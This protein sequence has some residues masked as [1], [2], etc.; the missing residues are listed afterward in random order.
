MSSSRKSITGYC[1]FIGDTLVSWKSK[2][3]AV[4]ARSS[5]EAEYRS[6]ASTCCELMWLKHLLADFKI[7][8][9]DPID[10][11]SDSQSAIHISKNPVFHEQTEHIE[12]DCHFIREKVLAST[13]K[14]LHISTDLQVV[15]IFTKALLPKQFY[16]LLGKMSVH[17]IHTS[18]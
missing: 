15:D 13:I 3:Q 1:V 9:D 16:K 12:M 7:D 10:L 18:S 6:M 5:A 11:Y 8:H 4:V 2:K 14:P 17:D